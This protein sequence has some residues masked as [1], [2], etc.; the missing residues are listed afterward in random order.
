MS[1]LS[2]LQLKY[3]NIKRVPFQTYDQD[4]TFI[5]NGEE[6][7][8]SRLVSDLL[9]PNICKMHLSDPTIDRFTI[10]IQEKGDFSHILQLIT[11]DQYEIQSNEIEFI[12]KVIE[13]LGNSDLEIMQ[14]NNS[15]QITIDNVFSLIQEHENFSIF[16]KKNYENE[17]EFISSHFYEICDS[18]YEE[19]KIIQYT[20]LMQIIEHDHLHLKNEDQLLKFINKIYIENNKYSNLYE[21]VLFANVTSKA[22]TEFLS[23]FDYNDLTHLLW[24]TLSSRLE[25]EIIT[26]IESKIERYKTDQN[27]ETNNDNNLNIKSFLYKEGQELNGIFRYLKQKTGQNIHDNG[28]ISISTN[29]FHSRH[30]PKNLVDLDTNNCYWTGNTSINAW[31]CF[32]FKNMKVEISS[33]SINS[34]NRNPGGSQIKNWVLEVSNDEKNWTEIDEHSN[35]DG[36]NGNNIIKTFN[37]KPNN[38]SRFV[39]IRQTGDYYGYPNVFL[40]IKSIEFYGK[41]SEN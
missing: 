10:N 36:L 22:M 28:T 20:T 8:T 35:Y 17:I 15:N 13:I 41:L 23:I 14:D 3:S 11:F 29:T 39:R 24:S 40:V 27:Q 1:K 16:Y 30:H 34:D 31:V 2:Q 21:N 32:D 5:V 9:S 37:V 12:I 26:K 19:L 7:K 18:H 38:F 6:F 25:K 33:Y 4:F